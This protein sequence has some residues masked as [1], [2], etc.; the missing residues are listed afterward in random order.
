MEEEEERR[1]RSYPLPAF[2]SQDILLVLDTRSHQRRNEVSLSTRNWIRDAKPSLALTTTIH[3]PLYTT[4]RRASSWTTGRFAQRFYRASLCDVRSSPR[5]AEWPRGRPNGRRRRPRAR[6]AARVATG[7]ATRLV[8][9]RCYIAPIGPFEPP[10]VTDVR[11]PWLP[12]Y[13]ASV[14]QIYICHLI[15]SVFFICISWVDAL[16]FYSQGLFHFESIAG[17]QML[18]LVC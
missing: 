9:R 7:A 8:R 11:S 15:Y 12:I 14:W 4:T 1:G 17:E 5:T 10:N 16:C 6:E 2:R 3:W 13:F 18:F